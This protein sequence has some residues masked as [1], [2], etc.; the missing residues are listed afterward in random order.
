MDTST[1]AALATPPGRGGL[2]VIRLSGPRAEAI[3]REL[4]LPSGGQDAFADRVLMHGRLVHQGQALDECMAVMMRAPRSYTREDVAEIQAHGG[5]RV[6]KGILKAV[7]AH[8][9]VPAQPGEFTRRAFEN[10]RIDLSQAEA[11]MQLVSASGQQAAD[12]AL[13]QLQGGTL[14]FVQD[15]Q[16]DLIRLMA[17]VTAAI[18]YPEEIAQEEAVG[19]AAPALLALAMRLEAACDERAVRILS[20]GLRV[21]ICGKPNAGKSSLLNALLLED[22]AI[23]TDIP[24][25]TRDMVTGAIELDGIRV[26]LTDTAG[27][28]MGGEAIERIGIQRAIEA[29]NSADLRLM[30]LDAAHSADAEDEAVLRLIAGRENLY[31]FNKADLGSHPGFM[32]WLAS[33]PDIPAASV[34]SL[35]AL[36][37]D[38]LGA[39]RQR[40]RAVAGDLGQDLLANERQMR[41]ARQAA[42]ALR[43]AAL[44]MEEG[45]SLDLCA[46]ELNEAL[47]SLG[48]I[49]GD[50]FSEAV[51]DEV[52]SAFCVGK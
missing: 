41:L 21:V 37:G 11:V 48:G 15:A 36:S 50:N 46:V 6:V 33:R 42:Q 20:E 17:G 45:K 18:D 14:R 29:V 27:I 47:A 16:T 28:R 3:L 13:R 44:A 10:G 43:R 23:V 30:V 1:I 24:G 19:Q 38:G 8:G 40:L 49:T 35:S 5:E 7:F 52:F 4:F 31:I 51:L 9:A 26:H 2:A 12:A 39:L 32:D 34:L 25:T 22:R